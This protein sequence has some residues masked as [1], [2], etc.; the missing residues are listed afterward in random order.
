[1]PF[2]VKV[3]IAELTVAVLSGWVMVVSVQWPQLLHR[4][5]L[6]H[7]Q[8]IR[9]AHLDLLFMGVILV[10][11][12]LAVPSVPGWVAA[13]ITIG[14]LG[15]PLTFLPLAVDARFQRAAFYRIGSGLLALGMSVGWVALA[16][17]VL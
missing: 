8:R 7:L 10:A 16:A 13:L 4:L 15:Q 6:R 1:M 14:A 2:L 12:G 3:G 5:G 9:Q 17:T 11:V